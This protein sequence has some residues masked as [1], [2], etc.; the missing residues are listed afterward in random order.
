M[1]NGHQPMSGISVFAE[2]TPE[3]L[4]MLLATF[5]IPLRRSSP[6]PDWPSESP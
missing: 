5:Y 2:G 3:C 4:V 1:R 6:R